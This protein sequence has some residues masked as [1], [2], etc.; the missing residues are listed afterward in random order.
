MSVGNSLGHNAENVEMIE[1]SLHR[2]WVSVLSKCVFAKFQRADFSIS[3]DIV[4]NIYLSA[5]ICTKILLES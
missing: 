3:Q 5:N 1:I 2:E 4:K